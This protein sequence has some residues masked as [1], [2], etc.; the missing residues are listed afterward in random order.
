MSERAKFKCESAVEEDKEG[1]EPPI[2]F[3][4]FLNKTC[5]ISS[6]AHNFSVVP[7]PDYFQFSSDI[8]F[9]RLDNTKMSSEIRSIDTKR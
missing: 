1:A 3:Q 9:L 5:V 7:F 6:G 4:F 2:P 8:I